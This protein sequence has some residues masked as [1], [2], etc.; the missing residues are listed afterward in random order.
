MILLDSQQIEHREAITY[1][2]LKNI[3]GSTV[4]EKKSSCYLTQILN[5]SSIQ[6]RIWKN[7]RNVI[8]GKL[9]FE[10]ATGDIRN[11]VGYLKISKDPKLE[12]ITIENM[13]LRESSIKTSLWVYGLVLYAGMDSKIMKN[14]KEGSQSR[15]WVI[16]KIDY[17]FLIMLALNIILGIIF[18]LCYIFTGTRTLST[19]FIVSYHFLMFTVALPVLLYI[20]IDLFLIIFRF[21]SLR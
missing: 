13:I 6:K 12:K 7:Y 1:V 15:K 2:D 14:F 4:C 8:S 16:S 3:N 10:K 9:R 17:I 21:R 20:A 11:F 19:S 18:T 5:R